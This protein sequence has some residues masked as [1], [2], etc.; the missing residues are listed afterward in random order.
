MNDYRE[1]GIHS[2]QVMPSVKKWDPIL[3]I[4]A[5]PS[6]SPD[7]S[8]PSRI[9]FPCGSLSLVQMLP[10]LRDVMGFTRLSVRNTS[11]LEPVSRPG[12]LCLCALRRYKCN[13]LRP[14]WARRFLFGATS[15]A[16]F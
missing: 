14:F 9:G 3:A 5:R 10:H 2:D 7:S 13:R 8:A 6:L 16:C 4:T 15:F 12:A 1:V 11:G